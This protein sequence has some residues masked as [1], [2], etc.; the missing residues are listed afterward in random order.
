MLAIITINSEGEG[1]NAWLWAGWHITERPI[2]K[3]LGADDLG[4]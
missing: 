1:V 4:A 2:K 3:P